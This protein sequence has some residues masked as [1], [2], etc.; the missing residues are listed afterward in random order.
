MKVAILDT[1]HPIIEE[2]FTEIGWKCENLFDKSREELIAIIADF[3]GIILRSRIKMDQAFLEHATSLK[4]IG[5][6]GAG[7]EN[8]DQEYCKKRGV[9]VFRSPE[10][11]RDA[12]AEHILGMLLSL[13]ANLKK[14]DIEVRNGIWLR[15]EN[16]GEELRGKTIGIIGYGFM[17]EAF[18]QRLPGF[19]VRILAYDKYISGFGSEDVEEVSLQTI[20][21]ES[22]I[23]SLHTPLTEETIGMINASFLSKFKKPIYFVNTARGKSVVTK[24]LVEKIKEGRVL[25]TCLDV[26]EYESSSFSGLEVSQLPEPM[27]FLIKSDKSVLTPHIAGWTKEARFKMGDF[28]TKKIL[29]KFPGV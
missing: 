22:D 24:D 1:V 14:A 11:N 29:D 19:G 4:F 5:R 15:E 9:E 13:F 7:L 23:V 8:I 20:F 6:P 16:R 2:K 12:V 18:A 28:L 27:H 17:G 21:E 25:G 26:L 10:G 3:D